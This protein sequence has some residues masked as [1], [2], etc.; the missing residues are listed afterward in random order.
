[1]DAAGAELEASQGADAAA[2]R[3]DALRERIPFVP[4]LLPYTM[5]YTNRPSGIQQV[6]SFGG[7]RAGRR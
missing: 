3:S 1:M 6:I 5:R 4:G 7:H 2:W